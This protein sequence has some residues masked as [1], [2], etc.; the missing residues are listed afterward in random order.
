MSLRRPFAIAASE[1]RHAVSGPLFWALILLAVLAATALDVTT[2]TRAAGA[3]PELRPWVNSQHAMA[4]LFAMSGFLLYG[5]FTALL[6]GLATI[7]DHDCGVSE[8]LHT[9]GL[10]RREY[11]GGKLVGAL[12]AL[13]LALAI[14]LALVVLFFQLG[15]LA[16]DVARG[17]LRWGSYLLPAL[18]FPLP[19]IVFAGGIAFAVGE[20]TRQP[21]A[22]FAVPIVIF[23][24]VVWLMSWT[25]EGLAPGLDRLLM[26][27]DPSG[28]RWLLRTV[29]SVD[30]GVAFYNRSSLPLDGVFLL[31]RVWT[32]A[33]PT[34]AV[35]W[36]ARRPVLR[37]RNRRRSRTAPSDAPA[38]RRNPEGLGSPPPLSA[39][40]S[41]T[42]GP[43]SRGRD[44]GRK[45][46]AQPDTF[47]GALKRGW[48]RGARARACG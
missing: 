48:P 19:M 35:L 9:T 8:L 34:A 40:G 28:L 41:S 36:A 22:V 21:I 6:A 24:A 17:P 12:A 47:P 23:V 30:R 25:P 44:A 5:F 11:L 4:W 1:L 31:N 13:V 26:V 7:R 33:L 3:S 43:G 45:L 27:V 20:R 15:P 32:L 39:D 18:L 46:R 38:A 10:G 42:G 14:H 37:V 29:L 16:A 2:F